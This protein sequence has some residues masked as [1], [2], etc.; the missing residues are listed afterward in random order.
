M[1]YTIREV[2]PRDVGIGQGECGAKAYEIASI[3]F[4][5]DIGKFP[6]ER[7]KSLDDVLLE[8][9]N[10]LMNEKIV[11]IW[12]DTGPRILNPSYRA[13]HC[14]FVFEDQPLQSFAIWD[15]PGP[16]FYN[17]TYTK[18]KISKTIKLFPDIGIGLHIVPP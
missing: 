14:Y 9:S 16:Q 7:Y 3:L 11:I 12:L 10:A 17:D 1:A 5:Q 13:I 2:R 6:E 8:I 15:S 18:A 4:D